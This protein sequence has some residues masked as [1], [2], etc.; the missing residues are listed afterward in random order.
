MANTGHTT[1]YKTTSNDR[2]RGI[3]VFTDDPSRRV[4]SVTEELA[5]RTSALEP[6][7][8]GTA[9]KKGPTVDDFETKKA[10]GS[11]PASK[12][13]LQTAKNIRHKGVISAT[14]N[15]VVQ[16]QLDDVAHV[17][18][19]GVKGK[20]DLGSK[21]PRPSFP[22]IML[23]IAITKDLL[24]GLSLTIIAAPLTS[25]NSFILGFILFM[26]MLGKMRGKWWKKQVIK[27]LWRRLAF[28]LLIE[29]L[30]GI[31]IIPTMTILVL[32]VHYRETK[33]VKAFNGLLEA[34]RKILRGKLPANTKSIA[35]Y[36][37]ELG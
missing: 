19:G 34:Y 23:A 32:M 3:R 7:T 11:K 28:F 35:L 4:H 26:W 2:R 6:A 25:L 22:A 9:T 21:A 1:A 18:N 14:N 31:N 15:A 8:L 30:P 27:I 36:S 29:L 20:V 24:D 17:L 12:T 13:V 10:L 5:N 16:K 37:S 33:V